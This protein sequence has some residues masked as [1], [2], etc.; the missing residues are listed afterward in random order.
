MKARR[1]TKAR[2]REPFINALDARLVRDFEG[3]VA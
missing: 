3:V 1:E 2:M